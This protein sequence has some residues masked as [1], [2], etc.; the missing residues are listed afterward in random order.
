MNILEEIAQYKIKENKERKELYP[1]KL[2][3]QSKYFES[4]TISMKE[5]ILR[6]DKSGIIAEFKRRSPSKPSINLYATPEEITIGYMQAGASALSILTDENYFGGSLKDLETARHF[7]YCPVLRKDF[8]IDEYQIIE[9]KSKGADAILLIAE[10]LTKEQ[11]ASL[12]QFAQSLGLEILMEIH[13]KE[14]LDKVPSTINLLGINNRN[15]KTF[16]VSINASLEIAQDLKTDL[17]LVSESGIK[18]ID[19]IKVLK[20]AGFEGFLIGEA[21]M[22]HSNPAEHCRMLAQQILA[23]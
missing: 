21:F 2:L 5:Y 13:S 6:P 20:D 18:G 23:L 22:K 19:S 17:T 14:Q 9:A 16:E 10:I 7:N 12:S 3:E 11:V 15:L 1:V 4:P 8:I